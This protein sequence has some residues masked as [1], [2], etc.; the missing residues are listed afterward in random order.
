[1]A[2]QHDTLPKHYD[3]SQVEDRWYAHWEEK[4]YFRS[5]PDERE[6]F[7]I[8]IPPPN[9]TGVLHMGHILNN[10]IQDILI[11]RARMMGKNACWVPGSDHAS[12][13]TEAK[14][15]RM[16]REQ[17]IKKSDLTREE[18]MKHAWAWKEKYGGIIFKQ[19]RKLGAS[20]DWER[21][22]FTMEP[23]LSDAVL[24]VF[25]DLH[26]KGHIYRG[27]RMIN[28]DP[29]AQTTLSNEEVIY[30]DVTAKLYYV[31]YQIEGRE[32]FVVVATTRPETIMGDTAVCFHPKD[33]RY[34]HLKGKNLIV[35]LINRPVPAIFDDYIDIE[36]G[37]GALKVTPAHDP[38]DYE[39]GQR[40]NLEVIDTL[41]ADGTLSEAAQ[42]HIGEDR[43]TARKNVAADLEAA[44]LLEKTEDLKH[45]VGFSERTNCVVE[46]R[47]SLQWFLAMEELCK[48]AI[49]VVEKGDVK[50]I[51]E[52][53][54]NTYRHW[55]TNIREWCISRQLWWGQRIPAWYYGEGEDDFVVCR[56]AEEAL[57]LARE[58]S[59]NAALSAEDI[60][61]DPD[62]LDTWASSWLWPISVFD[63]FADPDNEEIK[64]YYPTNV[65]VTGPDIL[66]FWV[67]R[68][69]IAG[70]EYREE[71]PFEHVYLTGMVRDSQR[72]KMSKSLGNS[73]DPLEI[74]KEYGA[75]AMRMGMM[76]ASSAGNDILFDMKL[77]EQGKNFANKIWSAMR[78]V[79][80]WETTPGSNPEHE[81][82]IAWFESKLAH[83]LSETNRLMEE[84][85]ISEA[86][87]NLY[88]F[89][90]DDFCSWYL[91]FIKPGFEQPIAEETYQKTL[92]YFDAILK[93]LH[94]FMPFI[95]EEIWSN[96]RE[97]DGKDI[98]VSSWPEMGEGDKS[99]L[100]AG[101]SAKD[102]ISKVRDLRNKQGLGF[103]EAY[104]LKVQAD[105][106]SAY[107]AFAATIIKIAKLE[108]FEATSEEIT[109]SLS[110]V[111][112]TSK[113]FF[114]AGGVDM[115]AEK[116]RILK[117]LEYNKGFLISV[118]KKLSNERFVSNAPE[119][120]VAKERQKQE[121]AQARI[122]VLEESLAQM[123]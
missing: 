33:E 71:R 82:A 70:M 112:G 23:A 38:N 108:S 66:F 2:N 94:P 19:L 89:I 56:T 1:M 111:S 117:E 106:L 29:E 10:T 12:I 47:L 65:L 98:T 80:T 44:G 61:Q 113:F 87:K 20:L 119:A 9:V 120:V 25:I 11:R 121:D 36:F 84:F 14:V 74:I 103:K 64:Y 58:K 63:G 15:V 85:R 27:L 97:R 50:L 3:P 39:I 118:E 17:G 122:K 79:K 81:A 100:A 31:R 16:L 76:I 109:G 48:P 42:I 75:D 55:M 115:E 101:E 51:P 43:E 49:E 57:E 102:I 4:G 62:V 35:P 86:L 60:H 32:D 68:M 26:K 22:R 24:D 13:A 107:E 40:H 67:A 110:F 21:E 77:V 34:A 123:N 8:V 72:R 46:P 45:S 5:V 104:P 105:D 53:F 92:D 28:W 91:E 95:T 7:T 93:I 116:E 73:P 54:I 30:R 6:P 88:S 18:F 78:L 52:K 90:W 59:G 69:I 83:T 37:T 114:E 96:L 99:I 41:N